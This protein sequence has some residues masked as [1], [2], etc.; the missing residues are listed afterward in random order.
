MIPGLFSN[1]TIRLSMILLA[2]PAVLLIIAGCTGMPSS[3]PASTVATPVPVV[4]TTAEKIPP[5]SVERVGSE[6][7]IIHFQ[8]GEGLDN[9]MEIEITV[10]D[11]RGTSKTQSLGTRQATTPVQRYATST[12]V[13]SF[14]GTTHVI[15]AGYSPNGSLTTLLD[16]WI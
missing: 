4:V 2:G 6:K 5:V 16:T 8:G 11:S 10:T 14:T 7:L 12:F 13:G 1:H 3:I 9:L 15:A